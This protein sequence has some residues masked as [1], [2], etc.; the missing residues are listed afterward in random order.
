MADG[1]RTS[2]AASAGERTSVTLDWLLPSTADLI[3]IAVLCALAFTALS[4]RLLGD[5]GIGWHIRTGQQILSTH[6]VPHFDLFSASTA[7]KHWFAWEWLYDVIVGWLDTIA[8]LNTVIWLTAAVIASVFGW[9]FRLLIL[10][11]TTLLFALLL[12]LLSMWASMIHFL[13]RPHV[14]SWLFTLA[15][16]WIL[17]STERTSSQS[18]PDARQRRLWLLPVLMLVWVNL[19]GGFLL[20]FALL[21]LYWLAS[22]WTWAAADDRR[23]EAILSRTAAKSRAAHLTFVG[24]ASFA[25]SFVNPYGWNLYRH[26]YAYLT[27][28]FLMDHIDEFQSPNFHGIA[29]K[30]FLLLLLVSIAV[31]IARGRSL[32][33][34][35]VLVALFAIYAALTA[36]RNLPISSVLLTMIAGPLLQHTGY[37]TEFSQ[38]MTAVELRTRGHFWPALAILATFFIALSGGRIGSTQAMDAHFGAKRMPVVAVNYLKS[39]DLQGPILSPDYWGGYLIYRLYPQAQVVV[40]DR[41]DL[42]GPDFFKSY[43]RMIHVEQGWQDFLRDHPARCV[44]LPRNSALANILLETRGWRVIYTDDLSIVFVPDAERSH[45]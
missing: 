6:A 16:F 21:G 11:G 2:S 20:G 10:R 34:S 37:F 42:Y 28:R 38:R 5:A 24:I 32:R 44:L 25:V 45:A 41:H 23:L 9:M 19:H 14:L 36:S 18:S 7:G 15:W 8:G 1:S 4:V 29:E 22:L 13:A 26:L 3:F 43:V 31:M 39:H 17:D 35:N 12:V 40:D 27:D 30:S 33:L